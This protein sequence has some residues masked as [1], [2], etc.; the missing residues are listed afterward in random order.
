MSSPGSHSRQK[1]CETL[2]RCVLKI[3]CSE[4]GFFYNSICYTNV[5][6]PE[7]NMSEE[8]RVSPLS[9]V[10]RPGASFS[11]QR[12][13]ALCLAVSN[14]ADMDRL[15]SFFLN[16]EYA[17]LHLF[18][19]VKGMSENM[20][21]QLV[22]PRYQRHIERGLLTLRLFPRK[23]QVSDFLDTIR[24]LDTSDCELF[25]KVG[26]RDFPTPGY[27]DAL[28]E[29]H[30][31][32]PQNCS[33]YYQ[34][35]YCEYGLVGDR[36]RV[37]M[38]A[39]PSFGVSFCLTPEAVA[40]LLACEGD[41]AQIGRFFS[42]GEDPRQGA[43]GHDVDG[44]IF[45]L[46]SQLGCG[47]TVSFLNEEKEIYFL[48]VLASENKGFTDTLAE[49]RTALQM[50]I[51]DDPDH[52]EYLLE[53][54][55]AWWR[56]GVRIL[57]K[58]GC[59]LQTGDKA[60]VLLFS[61]KRLILEWERWGREVFV[62]NNQNIYE[63]QYSA[64]PKME[65]DEKKQ[66]ELP[67]VTEDEAAGKGVFVIH[68]Y[69]QDRF[70]LDGE[71]GWRS[72]T[73]DKAAV[74]SFDENEL[75]IKWESWGRECFKRHT[76]GSYLFDS[77]DCVPSFE[78]TDDSATELVIHPFDRPGQYFLPE[79][80][81]P[82][83]T[84]HYHHWDMILYYERMYQDV[85]ELLCRLPHLNSVLCMG[86]CKDVLASLYLAVR[87]KR[88]YP[89]LNVGVFG[90]PWV[91]D[92][93]GEDLRYDMFLPFHKGDEKGVYYPDVMGKCGDVLA[94]LKEAESEGESIR[95]FSFYAFASIWTY[96]QYAAGRLSPYL[97]K[98][99]R[100]N[101][102][103]TKDP[104]DIHTQIIPLIRQH[105]EIFMQWLDEMFQIMQGARVPML[106]G[107]VVLDMENDLGAGS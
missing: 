95:C 48:T 72:K 61:K 68:P 99:Y 94:M 101:C 18:V 78:G 40:T 69:W 17:P 24:G 51:H 3:D 92:C 79:L 22:L 100:L 1:V 59:R 38:I 57:G 12:K 47:N 7:L 53:L 6:S 41:P 63:S 54:H 66:K 39:C 13:L 91:G 60:M 43:Y 35:D 87:I 5:M 37:K 27:L 83:I 86:V 74:Q 11:Q 20:F 58:E 76:G 46:I 104:M 44:L 65:G 105:P 50:S 89:S 90:C 85:A 28:N 16:E 62:K 107:E 26:E 32:L 31:T 102:P 81:R 82:V 84:L 10:E 30:A 23:N 70:V 8:N 93:R 73:K 97:E 55:H 75:V 19:A 64:R 96:D 21:R 34:G 25:L 45:T 67:F 71:M 36:Y 98:I 52:S 15:V 4:H 29:F 42:G 49:A 9:C 33:S 77:Y 103:D 14:M 88:D 2:C 56:D 106:G 80:H